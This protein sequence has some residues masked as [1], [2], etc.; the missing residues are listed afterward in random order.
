MNSRSAGMKKTSASAD[1]TRNEFD[2][3]VNQ[4]L[5]CKGSQGA[6]GC[7][8]SS[9]SADSTAAMHTV[10][11]GIRMGISPLQFVD[12]IDSGGRQMGNRA[13]VEW[14]GQQYAATD[15]AP[16][17]LQMKRKKDK[18]NKDVQ[19]DNESGNDLPALEAA[20][21]EMTNL[22]A[23]PDLLSPAESSTDSQQAG[24]L[25][26]NDPAGL[27]DDSLG[28]GSESDSEFEGEADD[29]MANFFPAMLYLYDSYT[30]RADQIQTSDHGVSS[31]PGI[32]NLLASVILG[33]SVIGVGLP[34]DL[35]TNLLGGMARCIMLL[36]DIF[37]GKPATWLLNLY[38]KHY[39]PTAADRARVT[40]NELPKGPPKG[41]D[42]NVSAPE[43]ITA[44]SIS[45][46]FHAAGTQGSLSPRLWLQPWNAARISAIIIR[47]IMD[48]LVY[49]GQF[50]VSPQLS[51]RVLQDRLGWSE[52]RSGLFISLWL[53][54]LG[55]IVGY[56]T[57]YLSNPEVALHLIF[58][59]AIEDNDMT[60]A[61]ATAA[62]IGYAAMGMLIQILS[63]SIF[64]HY[65][66]KRVNEKNLLPWLKQ[67][68]AIPNRLIRTI[69]IALAALRNVII[70]LMCITLTLGQIGANIIGPLSTRFGQGGVC[71]WPL[72][73]ANVCG[74]PPAGIN[75][76]ELAE[77]IDERIE[78]GEENMTFG[79]LF[80]IQLFPWLVGLITT[81]A[82]VAYVIYKYLRARRT[83]RA[84]GMPR[85]E[86]NRAAHRAGNRIMGSDV[87]SG[88]VHSMSDTVH[89]MPGEIEPAITGNDDGDQLSVSV[90]SGA[91]PAPMSLAEEVLFELLLKHYRYAPCTPS[92]LGPVIREPAGGSDITAEEATSTEEITQPAEA[93]ENVSQP[94]ASNVSVTHPLA[95]NMTAQMLF[96]WLLRRDR[97]TP[98][99]LKETLEQQVADG[100]I[101]TVEAELVETMVREEVVLAK[102]SRR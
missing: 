83:R 74:G 81:G 54:T 75:I 79:Q 97:L 43:L 18:G 70:N 6:A 76:T 36:C 5:A 39:P 47:V 56:I 13:F 90:C 42:W 4:T 7:S 93:R 19:P 67:F 3:G 12:S 89:S 23:N 2:A 96:E 37:P 45:A 26:G 30:K 32:G 71:F 59:N 65:V 50:T 58:Q 8:A 20:S 52:T 84:A 87:G 98:A 57:S 41:I 31:L 66:N 64:I 51:R 88:T 38:F 34:L 16:P 78:A 82:P 9:G 17:P 94:S 29:F 27:T 55:T 10:A 46:Y 44:S 62:V 86:E 21:L 24:L 61:Q 1:Q 91:S 22:I 100:N 28:S 40:S 85:I 48:D 92:G 53:T 35:L 63:T 95:E 14:V 77:I 101:T 73:V 60:S 68:R 72:A 25:Q 11:T 15:C 99:E 102:E 80:A 69:V 33:L 49:L